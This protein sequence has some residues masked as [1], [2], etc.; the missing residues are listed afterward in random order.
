MKDLSDTD[1]VFHHRMGLACLALAEVPLQVRERLSNWVDRLTAA[2]YYASG[3]FFREA[4]FR[5]VIEATGNL[6]GWIEETVVEDSIIYFPLQR[7]TLNKYLTSRL[8]SFFPDAV[9]WVQVAVPPAPAEEIARVLLLPFKGDSQLREREWMD[10]VIAKLGRLA[11]D[12]IV[13]RLIDHEEKMRNWEYDEGYC[14]RLQDVAITALSELIAT[15]AIEGTEAVLMVLKESVTETGVARAIH[16]IQ[17]PLIT[18]E[19]LTDLIRRVETGDV[20][21]A[22]ALGNLGESAAT[23]NVVHTLLR[24]IRNKNERYGDMLPVAT[25]ALAKLKQA[26]PNE[27]WLAPDPEHNGFATEELAKGLLE[28]VGRNRLGSVYEFLEVAR[29]LAVLG[30][31]GPTDGLLAALLAA[32]LDNNKEVRSVATLA[33]GEL[34]DF[35]DVAKGV[36]DLLRVLQSD[37]ERHIRSYALYALTKARDYSPT[38]EVGTIILGAVRLLSPGYGDHLWPKSAGEFFRGTT[39]GIDLVKF[40]IKVIKGHCSWGSGYSGRMQ[41]AD[42]LGALGDVAATESTIAVLLQA[43]EGRADIRMRSDEI[44][45]YYVRSHA[46]SSL[47]HLGKHVNKKEREKIEN[48]LLRILESDRDLRVDAALALKR[49]G[50]SKVTRESVTIL[51]RA[52]R[53]YDFASGDKGL[54]PPAALRVLCMVQ[55]QHP[56]YRF[57]GDRLWSG[58]N[59]SCGEYEVVDVLTLAAL[60]ASNPVTK[61]IGKQVRSRPPSKSRRPST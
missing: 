12:A 25:K 58:R 28:W 57:F 42:L 8:A 34:A 4:Y 60:P 37:S 11:S 47:G 26:T 13:Q 35:A 55:A 30:R 43:A 16:E 32:T 5:P 14:G 10:L 1:D 27:L 52:F 36:G 61:L 40:L 23:S 56:G 48:I 51:L 44:E 41:A 59:N 6:N 53:F 19:V 17:N 18:Q 22:V 3:N 50:V 20:P 7:S 24:A 45:H 33:I 54:V 15:G 39:T 49:L 31:F 46:I 29:T 9:R 2:M 21:A 38:E